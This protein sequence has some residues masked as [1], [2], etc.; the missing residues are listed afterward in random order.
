MPFVDDVAGN[1]TCGFASGKLLRKTIHHRREGRGLL[2]Q[3]AGGRRGGVA[4]GWAPAVPPDVLPPHGA[5]EV[6]M[7]CPLQRGWPRPR[8]SS[9]TGGGTHS[10]HGSGLYAGV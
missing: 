7:R 10:P 3:A 8:T 4:V 6:N 5:L 9:D 2:T 1:I